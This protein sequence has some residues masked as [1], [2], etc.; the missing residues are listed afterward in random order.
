LIY[1]ISNIIFGGGDQMT[2]IAS[3]TFVMA[4]LVKYT[5]AWLI[6]F[7]GGG[8]CF[9]V[10]LNSPKKIIKVVAMIMAMAFML[11]LLMVTPH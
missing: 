8:A 4:Y 7:F 1:Y 6:F 2:N 10:S 3:F 5:M 9:L 11:P